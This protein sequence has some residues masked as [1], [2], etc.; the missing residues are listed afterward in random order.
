MADGQQAGM[1]IGSVPEVLEQIEIIRSI[2][3]SS[4]PE[5]FD[6][7]S[8]FRRETDLQLQR[9]R[10]LQQRMSQRQHNETR[11]SQR[12]QQNSE[13]YKQ[14]QYHQQK[15]MQHQQHLQ[16]IQQQQKRKQQNEERRCEGMKI[17]FI[18]NWYF[19]KLKQVWENISY[20]VEVSVLVGVNGI[21]IMLSLKLTLPVIHSFPSIPRSV[22]I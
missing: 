11:S 1:E 14:Q 22:V 20:E 3:K 5:G 17:S 19:V 15:L 2:R 9:Q 7:D 4:L 16:R 8:E 18:M 6:S 12:N 10:D 21:S 13:Y